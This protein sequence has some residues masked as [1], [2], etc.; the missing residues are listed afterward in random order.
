MPT[1]RCAWPFRVPYYTVNWYYAVG[2]KPVGPVS[3]A[4]LD[5]LCANGTITAGSLVTQE[6]M[7]DWIPYRDLKKTTQTLPDMSRLV[8]PG[9][10]K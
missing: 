10:Q 8:K 4:D 3:R 2:D 5:V 6:G 1:A 9:E 7:Y